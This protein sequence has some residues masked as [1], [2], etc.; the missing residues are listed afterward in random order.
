M[1]ENVKK[2]EEDVQTLRAQYLTEWSRVCGRW[3][4]RLGPLNVRKHVGSQYIARVLLGVIV[5]SFLAGTLLLLFGFRDSNVAALGVS[6]IV[7]SIFA[8]ASL[9]TELW[10]QQFDREQELE[11]LIW[12]DRYDRLRKTATEWKT[13]WDELNE[14]QK[15]LRREDESKK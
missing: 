13:K 1:E 11:D 15:K 7:G 12:S 10:S 8:C 3:R 6:L 2:L 5:V 14:E 4:I 9:L